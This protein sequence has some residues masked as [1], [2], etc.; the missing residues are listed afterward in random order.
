MIRCL[1]VLSDELKTFACHC[2]VMSEYDENGFDKYGQHRIHVAA[3]EGDLKAVQAELDKGVDVDLATKRSLSTPLRYAAEGNQTEVMKLLLS[4]GANVDKADS[5]GNTPL[6]LASYHGYEVA[7]KLLLEHK[8]NTTLKDKK[9]K[10]AL[11]SAK[12]RN[13]DKVIALLEAHAKSLNKPAS[14]QPVKP[15]PQP[16]VSPAPVSLSVST[17]PAI[18]PA[19]SKLD[20]LTALFTKLDLS[21]YVAAFAKEKMFVS[22]FAE[23]EESDIEK[24]IPEVCK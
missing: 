20:E 14:A 2:R 5:S 6:I 16:S 18:K 9:G 3:G 15:V 24:L 19:N 13:Q 11:D 21:E 10:T 22:D 8:A 23:L 1:F 17:P 7:V 4:R 12:D